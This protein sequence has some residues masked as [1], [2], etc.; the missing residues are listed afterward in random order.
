MV[1]WVVTV[2]GL[3]YGSLIIDF[4]Q[5]I[6]LMRRMQTYLEETG[7]QHHHPLTDNDFYE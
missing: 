3:E 4:F 5:L 7:E 1:P 2:T 6:A